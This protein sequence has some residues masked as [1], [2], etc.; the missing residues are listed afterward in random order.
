[1]GEKSKTIDPIPDEFATI[2][3]AAAFW[4]SHDFGDYWDESSEVELEVN[5]PRHQWVALANHLAAQ[6]AERARQEGVTVE[7]L[8]NLWIAERLVTEG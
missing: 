5:A 1:M 4:E 8:I 6:A 3:E 2:E 7:T